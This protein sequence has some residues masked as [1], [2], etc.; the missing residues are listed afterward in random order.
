LNVENIQHGSSPKAKVVN[1]QVIHFPVSLHSFTFIKVNTSAR[2]FTQTVT[3][4]RA[5]ELK[6]DPSLISALA[7]ETFKLFS[8]AA[9][10]LD[11]LGYVASQ[12]T[13]YLRLRLLCIRHMYVL[14]TSVTS[15]N[16]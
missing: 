14:I 5:V 12:W 4:A 15:N 13:R 11:P 10:T 2:D 3:L 9:G 1:S 16:M 8:D 6:H 7:N